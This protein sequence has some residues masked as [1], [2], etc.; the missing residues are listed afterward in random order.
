MTEI[1]SAEGRPDR[2]VHKGALKGTGMHIT[3]IIPALDE[4]A[5]I[6]NV[7]RAIPRDL[8]QEITGVAIARQRWPPTPG[9]K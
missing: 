8:V 7:I 6:G 1:R 4:E 2:R 3:V 5:A 9:P